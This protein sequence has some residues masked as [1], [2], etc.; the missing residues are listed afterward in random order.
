M[1]YIPHL[2]LLFA[3]VN[4]L[5]LSIV[6]PLLELMIVSTISYMSSP[7]F[8]HPCIGLSTNILRQPSSRIP[9]SLYDH[10]HHE[11]DS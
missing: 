2:V 10:S 11:A 6:P 7:T 8:Q 3:I 4:S 5:M 1:A 9:F